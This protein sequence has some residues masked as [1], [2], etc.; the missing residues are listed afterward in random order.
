MHILSCVHSASAEEMQKLGS[1]LAMHVV[2][3]KPSYLTRD[4]VPAEA[5]EAE[6]AIV[7][8]QAEEKGQNMKFLD[9]MVSVAKGL[10]LCRN[11]CLTWPGVA[12]SIFV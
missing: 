8:K 1:N 12:L 7:V 6:K 2:A 10:G 11:T 9:R 4:E 3:A 5:V